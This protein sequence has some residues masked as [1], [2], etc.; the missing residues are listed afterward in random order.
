SVVLRS[1]QDPKRGRPSSR[2]IPGRRT[3]QCAR[4]LHADCCRGGKPRTQGARTSERSPAR[5]NRGGVVGGPTS[6]S[7]LETESECEFF[8][9]ASQCKIRKTKVD[10]L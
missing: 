2:A 7:R 8:A 10:C 3:L 1:L 6:G 4:Q 9:E 5:Y